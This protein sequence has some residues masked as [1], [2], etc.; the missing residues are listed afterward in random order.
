MSFEAI[1][2]SIHFS[3][4]RKNESAGQLGHVPSNGI[5]ENRK[6]LCQVNTAVG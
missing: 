6:G 3:L 5:G 1:Q 2:E 4:L